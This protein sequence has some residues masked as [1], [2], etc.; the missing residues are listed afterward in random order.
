MQ[1]I[2]RQNRLAAIGQDFDVS[3]KVFKT[4]A[5][6]IRNPAPGVNADKNWNYKEN[7]WKTFVPGIIIENS[8]HNADK[9]K[10][11]N[12]R[13]QAEIGIFFETIRETAVSRN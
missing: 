3:V 7:R 11:H 4:H 12:A 1:N 6:D 2:K 9:T 10:S 13:R 8:Q 5:Q